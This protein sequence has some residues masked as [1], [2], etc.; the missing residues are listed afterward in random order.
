[1]MREECFGQLDLEGGQALGKCE[2][3]RGIA[4]FL[5]LAALY[6]SISR[7]NRSVFS[8]TKRKDRKG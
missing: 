4:D 6:K 3:N 5:I 8:A 2:T 7:F 1:M